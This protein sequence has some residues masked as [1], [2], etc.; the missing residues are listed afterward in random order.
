LLGIAFRNIPL[1]LKL[2]PTIGF[3]GPATLE[4]N[5]CT[6]PL[7]FSPTGAEENA[8]EIGATTDD[9]DNLPDEGSGDEAS[10]VKSEQKGEKKKGGSH[11][12]STPAGASV[13]AL[14]NLSTSTNP[15]QQPVK[16]K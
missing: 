14:K 16:K 15:T 4:L 3:K 11:I 9:D 6:R 2:R 7:A 12:I 10:G 8:E 13:A 5:L 1:D